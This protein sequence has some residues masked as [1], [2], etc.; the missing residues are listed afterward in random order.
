MAS[1]QSP[2]RDHSHGAG[3]NGLLKLR[4]DKEDRALNCVIHACDVATAPST[5]SV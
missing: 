3:V 2:S 1:L 4:K 5:V